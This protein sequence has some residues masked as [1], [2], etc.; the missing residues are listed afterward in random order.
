M[1]VTAI[2][3]FKDFTDIINRDE[4]SVIH[5][6]AT[7][8]GPCRAISP[9]F[10]DLSNKYPNVKCYKV[11]VDE[12]SDIAQEAGLRAMPTFVAFRKGV[13]IGDVSGA[14]PGALENFFRRVN[15]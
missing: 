2:K 6:W 12:Q 10:E 1:A 11:D 13:K 8:S 14:D 7:W 9:I 4:A 3:S 15:D 5:F